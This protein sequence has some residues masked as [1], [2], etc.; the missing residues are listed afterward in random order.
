MW[1]HCSPR[2]KTES[3]NVARGEAE[4]NNVRFGLHPRAAVTSQRAMVLTIARNPMQYSFYYMANPYLFIIS[5]LPCPFKNAFCPLALWYIRFTFCNLHPLFLSPNR[6]FEYCI[7]V[8]FIL[9]AVKYLC[10]W[11]VLLP[12]QYR[13]KMHTSKHWNMWEPDKYIQLTMAHSSIVD[14]W[15]WIYSS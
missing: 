14:C 8:L 10:R 2:V 6:S 7:V 11:S 5:R 4:G 9:F 12:I 15:S 1:R 3:C 13:R